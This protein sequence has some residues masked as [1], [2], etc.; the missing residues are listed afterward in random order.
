MPVPSDVPGWAR[1]VIP[2]KPVDADLAGQPGSQPPAVPAPPE[3]PL[4]LAR[5]LKRRLVVLASTKRWPAVSVGIGIGVAGVLRR[6][7]GSLDHLKSSLSLARGAAT[8]AGRPMNITIEPTNACNLGCPVC[9]TGDGTLGRT[10]GHMTFADFKSIIDKIGTHTNT[11]MFYFMGE[12]FLNKHAYDMIRYAKDAGIPF[13]DTCTNG[14]FA[15]P[16]KLVESG[17]DRVAFQIGGMTQETHEVYRVRSQLARVLANLEETL[18]IR[19]ARRAPL[20]IECGFI[21]MR[22]NEH[23]VDAFRRRMQELGVDRASV[24]DPLV[25]TVE[26]GKEFLPSDKRHWLYDERAFAGGTL[27]PKIVP[28]NVCP[29]I[30]Y[31]MA[32]H[33]NGNVVPCCRDPRGSEVM[34]NILTQGLDEIWNGPRYRE[35][36]ERIARDQG[37][38]EICRLCSSYPVSRIR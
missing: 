36:R 7:R 32:I 35:L 22:H 28:D 5:R 33:T 29:W 13:I 16:V 10:T 26:Q 4:G 1:L 25:R 34:G 6:Q 15:D 17:L 12:P 23:E 37:S 38:V 30:Y 9:E 21:L 2:L 8:I 18:R 20:R 27:R 14:D 3:A 31:S 11:L 19:N 24:I